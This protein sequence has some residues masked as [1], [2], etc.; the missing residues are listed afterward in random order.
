MPS[1]RTLLTIGHSTRPLGA[2]LSLGAS[3]GIIRIADVRRF[4]ASRR[5]PHFGQ[6]ALRRTLADSGV[7]YL[8]LPE[9]GGR[10][11]RRKDSAN[12]G[13]KVAAFA[14]YAD[15]MDTDEFHG[16][17]TRLLEAAGDADTAI[18]CAEAFPYQCHRRLISDWLELHGVRVEHILTPARRERHRVTP[19]VR[20]RDGRL[21]YDAGA[22]LSLAGVAE[23]EGR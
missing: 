17:V 5:H 7:G 11:A 2:F 20:Y 8:W 6:D 3:H 15:H 23:G 4:P 22:Q 9:L 19:F 13:W 10:R 14:G 1:Q 16:G 21:I 12:V 18:M